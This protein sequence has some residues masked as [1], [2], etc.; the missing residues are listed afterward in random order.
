MEKKIKFFA[1][2][3]ILIALS[4]LFASCAFIVKSSDATTP[5]A[6]QSSNANLSALAVSSGTLSPAFSGDVTAYT[7]TVANITAQIT[8]TGTKADSNATV[9]ANNGVAQTLNF[10]A[11]T[12]TITVTAQNGTKKDYTVSVTRS[13]PAPLVGIVMPSS[14]VNDRWVKDGSMISSTLTSLNYRSTLLTGDNTSTTDCSNIQTLVAAGIN[15]LVIAPVDCYDTSFLTAIASAKTAGVKIIS[16]D[17]LIMNSSNVDFYTSFDNIKVGEIMGQYLVDKAGAIPG[18]G[19][20]LYLYTG[21]KEDNNAILFFKGAWNKLQPKIADGT[22]V[23]Q[24]SS[25]ASGLST[26]LN[27]TDAQILSIINQIGIQDWNP[28]NATTLATANLAAA[29]TAKGSVY[30][31]A[32]NDATDRA[33]YDAFKADAAVTSVVITGQDCEAVSVQRIIDGKQSMTILK[34][35]K[36]LAIE[37]AKMAIALIE[38]ST[39]TID[40][41]TN[42]G[43]K[44]L[45]SR[46]LTATLI[47]KS[48]I[49]TEIFDTGYYKS[50]D[51]D[52]TNLNK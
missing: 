15:A 47:T 22:F 17:R 10:G 44:N 30:I 27:L 49:Q 5:A 6:T 32:P 33:I 37:T 51:F 25:V 16:Y 20:P 35:T 26:T 42:N 9:S 39:P 43:A 4:V 46:L 38:G 21:T 29:G 41:Q 13:T 24:N 48:N 7:V 36:T 52:L 45:P 11:N 50:S 2:F 40:A 28:A 12:V 3:S 8:V 34:N 31:I 18:S 1:L 14:S 19:K 23:I